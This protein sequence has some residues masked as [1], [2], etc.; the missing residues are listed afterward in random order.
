[1]DIRDI[2]SNNKPVSGN[3][4][5]LK[6]E[7]GQTL[8]LRFLDIPVVFDSEYQGKTST[9]YAWLVYNHDESKVQIYQGGATIY[10]ALNDL[11]QDSDWGD[12]KEYDVK[13]SRN[14]VGKET[15]YALV[16]SPKSLPLPE[17]IE[18]IDILAIMKKS[19]YNENVHMLGEMFT[20]LE[21]EV[22]LD[23]IDEAPTDLSQIPF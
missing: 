17:E 9:K 22:V 23:D 13:V 7:S 2:Y 21:K 20:P 6:L 11:I 14:G 19:P 3:G 8:R 18:D 10:N 1:M 5:F 12:P 4:L 16:A 15:K